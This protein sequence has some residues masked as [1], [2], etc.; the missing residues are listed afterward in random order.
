[1]CFLCNDGYTHALQFYIIHTLP[2]LYCVNLILIMNNT[3]AVRNNSLLFF[4]VFPDFTLSLILQFC[5]EVYMMMWNRGFTVIGLV[6]YPTIHYWWF[7]WECHTNKTLCFHRIGIKNDSY[8][9]GGRRVCVI[10]LSQY[11]KIPELY[12]VVTM[13]WYKE[14]W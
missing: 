8:I 4:F 14:T 3:K 2:V 9:R 1:M 13:W 12:C 7:I 6:L 10:V 11:R 5:S